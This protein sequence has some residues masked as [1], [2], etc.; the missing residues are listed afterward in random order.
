[1][2]FL[3]CAPLLSL[4][5]SLTLSLPLSHTN[6]HATH[7]QYQLATSATSYCTERLGALQARNVSTR[8][9]SHPSDS[10]CDSADGSLASRKQSQLVFPLLCCRR[11]SL[12]PVHSKDKRTVVPL[13]TVR[14]LPERIGTVPRT[15]QGT[16]LPLKQAHAPDY[17]SQW[18]LRRANAGRTSVGRGLQWTQIRRVEQAT[19]GYWLQRCG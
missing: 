4:P 3:S 1:M 10:R 9:H 15:G 11:M 7:T 5:Y 17:L 12:P 14:Y 13:E 19:G 8:A 18:L 2:K 16:A 6:T